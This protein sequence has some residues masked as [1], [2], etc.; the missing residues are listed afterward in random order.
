MQFVIENENLKVTVNSVGCEICSIVGK[1][2]AC[3]YLWN[4]DA[5]F[6]AQ[7]APTMFPICGRL[8]EGKYT[9]QG[10]TYEMNLHGFAR[11]AEFTIAEKTP[12]S[13]SMTLC[14][15]AES[16][17]AYPFH[18]S[19]TITHTLEENTIRTEYTVQNRGQ[20]TMYY[21]LGGHPGFFVPLG[22]TGTFE[23]CYLEF[24][25]EMPAKQLVLSERCFM[26]EN[27]V[28]FA[29]ENGVK[30][31]LDHAM[32]DNDAIFLM[33]T[34][35]SVTLKSSA[36]SRFV[37]VDFPDMKYIG[38]WHKPHT[39]APYIC[40]EPWTGVPAY[41][42]KIDALTEKRDMTELPAGQNRHAAYSITIG[43]SETEQ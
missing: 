5:S 20:E 23:D 33:D 18:F 12:T 2:D 4:G 16:F 14:D 38:F 40:I 8:W 36:S 9:Y 1:A 26:T 11:F 6:W 34:A 24:S 41:D 27:T 31:V 37:R 19:F 32:F 13:I 7:H 43:Q 15:N 10:N 21:A 30:R 22:N 28:P 3:E 35:K 39:A 17:S 29:L 42:G 25:E